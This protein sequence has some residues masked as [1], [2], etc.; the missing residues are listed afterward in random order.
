MICDASAL[1]DVVHVRTIEAEARVVY[2][3]K[4]QQSPPNAGGRL[5]LSKAFCSVLSTSTTCPG[6][7]DSPAL[8]VGKV[9]SLIGA[10]WH[11]HSTSG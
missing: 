1:W 2:A 5:L 8:L 6:P 9:R 11:C 4:P 3:M 7:Y 10:E